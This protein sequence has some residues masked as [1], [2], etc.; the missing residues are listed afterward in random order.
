MLIFFGFCFEFIT[1]IRE[2]KAL[3]RTTGLFGSYVPFIESFIDVKRVKI[4]YLTLRIP[5]TASS[6]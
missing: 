5:G 6:Q 1:L 2:L 3:M 4:K